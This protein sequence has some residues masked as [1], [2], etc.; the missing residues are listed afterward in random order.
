MNQMHWPNPT[1]EPLERVSPSFANAL[2]SCEKKAAYSSDPR[3]KSLRRANTRTV[4]GSAAHSLIEKVL[5]G[6]APPAGKRNEWLKQTWDILMGEA[7]QTLKDD[8]PGRVVPPPDVW[9]GSIATRQRLLRRLENTNPLPIP[10][11]LNSHEQCDSTMPSLPWV[12]RWLED[13]S[14]GIYGKPD[15]VLE[16]NGEIRVV[17]H[18]TGVHQGEITPSQKQQLLVY[19]HLVGTTLNQKVAKAVVVDT[20]GIEFEFDVA[21]NEVNSLVSSIIDARRIFE[22]HRIEGEFVASPDPTTC[23]YCPFRS[24]CISYWEARN[25]GSDSSWPDRDVRGAFVRLIK[26]RV[27][28]LDVESKEFHLL[29]AEGMEFDAC[30]EVI[31]TNLEKIT[32]DFSAKARW[33]STVRF[34]K[35]S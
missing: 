24:V 10:G 18:K 30:D 20:K 19:A 31:A 35:S 14:A 22:S 28:V 3:F 21:Q 26:P 23:G 34:V 7:Y 4:L 12:E 27:V 29:L 17:D 13:S 9:P 32:E 11:Q 5:L 1:P 8:W 16:S 15:L 6:E 2:L 33:D 25:A